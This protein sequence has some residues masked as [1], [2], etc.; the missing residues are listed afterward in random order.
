MPNLTAAQWFR[1]GLNNIGLAQAVAAVVVEFR[2]ATTVEA[3]VEALVKLV[4]LFGSIYE[5]LQAVPREATCAEVLE[6]QLL[7]AIH[8]DPATRGLF[9]RQKIG[10]ALRLG[11]QIFK[12]LGPM[13]APEAAPWI[14]LLGKLEAM[15]S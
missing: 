4:R 3:K 9:D 8:D 11:L 1:W 7:D 13:V 15:G 14:E 5:S 12:V 2:E 6:T 10:G